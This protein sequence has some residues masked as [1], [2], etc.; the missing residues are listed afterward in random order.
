MSVGA[1]S[2][3][4]DP[5]LFDENESNHSEEEKDV[6]ANDRRSKVAHV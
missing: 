6:S 3:W 5:T 4:N 2:S 1:T